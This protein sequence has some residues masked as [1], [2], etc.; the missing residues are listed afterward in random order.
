MGLTRLTGVVAKRVEDS[1]EVVQ[2]GPVV[3]VAVKT[4]LEGVPCQRDTHQLHGHLTDL[5]PHVHVCGVQHHGLDKRSDRER[6]RARPR[7]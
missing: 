5:V 3:R 4:L 6:V 7:A 1:D 2:A